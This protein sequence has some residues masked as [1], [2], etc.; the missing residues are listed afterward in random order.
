MK[1]IA[2]LGGGMA[3]LTTAYWLTSQP[4]WEEAYE[5]TVHQ[6]GW[7]LGGK[8]ASGQ[9]ARS[10][11]RTE[12][13][14]Y[15]MLFGFYENAFATMRGCYDAL[16]RGKDEPLAEFCAVD[17]ADETR[18]PD[19]YAVKRNS[20][21]FLAQRFGTGFQTIRFDFP[22]NVFVPGDGSWATSGS[23]W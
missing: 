7:R 21:L 20:L 2:I 22:T 10:W 17:P 9:N 5:I 8:A 1:K 14:G 23:P 18:Y 16:G 12:E 15:H 13:H 19:R 6:L 3:S 4:G 11:Q